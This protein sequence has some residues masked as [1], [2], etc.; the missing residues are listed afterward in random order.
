MLYSQM[1]GEVYYLAYG[2]IFAAELLISMIFFAIYRPRRRYFVFRAFLCIIFFALLESLLW[3]YITKLAGEASWGN[4]I[5]YFVCTLL[6]TG[7]IYLCFQVNALGAFYIATGAYAVQH[8]AYSLGNVFKYL[9]DLSLPL[10]AQIIVYDFLLYGLVGEIFFLIFIRPR[11]HRIKS[12]FFDVRAFAISLM[13]LV[14][15]SGLSL[16]VDNSFASYIERGI[17]VRWLRIY[18]SLYALV[19]SIASIIIQFSFLR[20]NRLT[21]ETEILDELIRSESKRHEMSKETID[22]INE[23]CHDIKN[24]IAVLARMDDVETRKA[25]IKDLEN[26]IAIYDTSAETGNAALDIVISEKGLLCEKN[27]IAFSCLVDGTKLSFMSAPDLAS[28]FGNALDNA[29]E[30]QLKEKEENRFISLSVSEEAGFLHVHL[31]NCCTESPE[32]RGGLP[33]TDKPD[34]NFHGFGTK[35]IQ[36]IAAKYYGETFMCVEDNRFNLDLLFPM[37]E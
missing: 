7:G 6:L 8:A 5:F 12:D 10:W 9:L 34:E 35:S 28:L 27:N 17:D 18:C 2:N 30:R 36:N 29:I 26:R 13:T 3:F 32:F 24:Q 19:G 31:D 1:Y 21:N 37:S 4:A 15:C 23:K 14:V 20:E 25:Y 11:R 33:H 16:L 22:I